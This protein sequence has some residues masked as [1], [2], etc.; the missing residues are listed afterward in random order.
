MLLSL[1]P[2][3]PFE[4]GTAERVSCY[5]SLRLSGLLLNDAPFIYPRKPCVAKFETLDIPPGTRP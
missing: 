4:D 1:L 5:H 3:P 2:L